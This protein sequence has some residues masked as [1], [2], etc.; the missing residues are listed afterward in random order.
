MVEDEEEEGSSRRGEEV[1]FKEVL[2]ISGGTGKVGRVDGICCVSIAIVGSDSVL[3]LNPTASK[4][5]NP[6]GRSVAD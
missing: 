2:S 3:T 5:Y 6:T 1:V 4:R